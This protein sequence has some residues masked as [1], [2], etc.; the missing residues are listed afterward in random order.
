MKTKLIL[1][2]TVLFVFTLQV[3]ATVMHCCP[4]ANLGVTY[5][6]G[7]PVSLTLFWTHSFPPP[8]CAPITGFEV[9]VRVQGAG[10]NSAEELYSE[11][12]I[13]TVSVQLDI[14]Q[15][16]SLVWKV[17]SVYGNNNG[18]YHNGRG[19]GYMSSNWVSGPAFNGPETRIDSWDDDFDFND[20]FVFTNPILDNNLKVK[21]NTEYETPAMMEII[22]GIGQ[23]VKQEKFLLYGGSNLGL[24]D[25]A[26][27][28]NGIY[29]ARVS[30]G[31]K[32]RTVRF[33]KL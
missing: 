26:E 25:V 5:S 6:L 13:D 30:A 14:P 19:V 28:H 16:A 22:N 7:N 2:V 8:S 12:R 1:L 27:L 9:K 18:L 24:F 33:M 15:G 32:I 10:N 3:G 11:D 17:R 21:I 29:F 20:L 4:P 31:N 23:L